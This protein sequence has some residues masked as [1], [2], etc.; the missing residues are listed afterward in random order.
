MK[1]TQSTEIL[2]PNEKIRNFDGRKYQGLEIELKLGDTNNSGNQYLQTKKTNN[3]PFE[4]GGRINQAL[5]NH[6]ETI[7]RKIKRLGL[8]QGGSSWLRD[9]QIY[10]SYQEYFNENRKKQLAASWHKFISNQKILES[11]LAAKL[12][13]LK[14]SPNAQVSLEFDDF[15]LETLYEYSF[16]YPEEWNS[17]FL[18]R[19]KFQD[20]CYV[21]AEEA[22]ANLKPEKFATTTVAILTISQSLENTRKLREIFGASQRSPIIAKGNQLFM[23]V[24]FEDYPAVIY[25]IYELGGAVSKN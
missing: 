20:D 25:N 12:L 8:I 11:S 15:K 9:R 21:S 19:F 3:F 2:L 1:Q 7:I 5:G 23:A 18:S 6:D 17:E 24:R 4:F 16:C 22:I 13:S 14:N 10:N